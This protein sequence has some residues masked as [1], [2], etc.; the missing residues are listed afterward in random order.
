MGFVPPLW[1]RVLPRDPLVCGSS[2][3]GS[4]VHLEA[5][6]GREAAGRASVSPARTEGHGR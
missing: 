2:I 1:G 4:L 5:E 3:W 6:S